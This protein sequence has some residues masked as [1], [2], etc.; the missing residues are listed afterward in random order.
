MSFRQQC[1]LS[2]SSSDWRQLKASAV[3]AGNGDRHWQTSQ[4]YVS[5]Q[6]LTLTCLPA[7]CNNAAAGCCNELSWLLNCNAPGASYCQSGRGQND[8]AYCL[9]VCDRCVTDV[10][11]MAMLPHRLHIWADFSA[12]A[13]H[14]QAPSP[15]PLPRVCSCRGHN[16]DSSRMTPGLQ[17]DACTAAAVHIPMTVAEASSTI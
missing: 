11:Q 8:A 2:G 10:R 3:D 14:K 7:A 13:V 15:R 16:S 9:W 5:T 4:Y 1:G 12:V 6:L 17:C